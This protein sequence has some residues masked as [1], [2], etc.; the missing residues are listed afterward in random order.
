MAPKPKAPKLPVKLTWSAM[1]SYK[2]SLRRYDAS[3]LANG[4][5][6]GGEIQRENSLF[7]VMGTHSTSFRRVS[8][9]ALRRLT[10]VA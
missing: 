8:N 7:P 2:R 1:A 9:L 4:I 10:A 6:T 5:T 3:R